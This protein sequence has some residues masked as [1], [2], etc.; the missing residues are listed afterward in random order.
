MARPMFMVLGLVTA[1]M[2]ALPACDDFAPPVELTAPVVVGVVAEPPVVAPGARTRLTPLIATPDGPVSGPASA[3]SATWTLTETLPGVAPFGELIPNADGSAFYQAPMTLPTLPPNALP[4]DSVQLDVVLD[5]RKTSVLKAVLVAS[6]PTAN[7]EIASL[8]ADGIAV[9][10]TL[11]LAVGTPAELSVSTAPA[12]TDRA[13]YAWYTSVGTIEQYQS[14]PC[15][16]VAESPGSGWL[17][18]VVRDGQ[19][20]VTWRAV[21]LVVR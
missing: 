11:E 7:P 10:D 5:G 8:T 4:L 6:L 1:T 17:Y 12:A 13:R 16:L 19:L 3:I 2:T 18:V 14:S 20:G 21:P 15:T 9:A